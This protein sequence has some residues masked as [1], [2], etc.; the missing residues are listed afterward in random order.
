VVGAEYADSCGADMITSSLGYNTFDDAAFDHTYNDFYKNKALSTQ[1][2]A[3]AAK[4]GILVTNSAGNEGGNSWNYLGFPSDADSV[5]AVGAVNAGGTVAS[6]SSYGYTGKVKPNIASVGWNTYVAGPGNTY[7][8]GSGTSYANPNINGLIACLW[9]AFPQYNNMKILDA[10]YKSCPTYTT[11]DN[12]V[13]YG[14]P[15]M[16]KAYQLLKK[17]QNTALYG[18]EW[19]WASPNPFTTEINVQLIGQVEGNATLQLINSSNTV[20]A[21]LTLTTEL[22]EVYNPVFTALGNLPAGTYT[23]KYTDAGKTRS[24]S[25]TKEGATA[26]KDWLIAYPVPFQNQLTVYLTA[27]ET[28]NA[29]L[30][31]LSSNGQLAETLQLNITQNT[32]Y[33]LT[34]SKAASLSAG[35]YQVQY[36]SN[37]QKKTVSVVKRNK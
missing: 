11:P 27:P 12:R 21:T 2:A 10:V 37:T 32:A 1:G 5:C 23:V 34:F 3:M 36:I 8:Y 35:V 13:G 20:V 14:I 16:K 25:L 31:L 17:E 29:S 7:G 4:K 24:I 18:N 15:N 26:A 6:F 30:R 28:G 22:E 9:Q 33:T 19:L